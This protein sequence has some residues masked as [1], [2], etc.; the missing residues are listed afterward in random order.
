MNHIKDLLN[1]LLA[2]GRREKLLIL[3]VMDA[4]MIPAALW[5]TWTQLAGYW[6]LPIGG[7]AEMLVVSTV[8]SLACLAISGVYKAVVRAFDETFLRTLLLA[9]LL[10]SVVLIAA[11]TMLPWAKQ[12]FSAA[13]LSTVFS[14]SLIFFGCGAAARPFAHWGC[15]WGRWV[16]RRRGW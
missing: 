6:W 9:V 3:V 2:S 4:L 13:F 7:G 16:R 10:N 1:A 15:F 5:L 11:L 12:P 14:T 8:V